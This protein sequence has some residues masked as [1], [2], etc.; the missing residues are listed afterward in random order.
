MAPRTEK[1]DKP[2][3]WIPCT[4]P[5]SEWFSG[6]SSYFIIH[7]VLHRWPTNIHRIKTEL[8]ELQVKNREDLKKIIKRYIYWFLLA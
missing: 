5:V 2:A 4:N 3:Q 1:S 7:H 8:W 6:V